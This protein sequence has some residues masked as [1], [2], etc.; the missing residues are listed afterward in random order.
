MPDPKYLTAPTKTDQMPKGIPYIIA[1]EAA[2]RFSY[3]GM[4]AILAVF[5][6]QYL[7]D[8][9]GALAVMSE[10]EANQRFHD[11]AF[12]GYFLPFVG[13]F[14]ADAFLG[15]YATILL[16]SAVYCGGHLALALDD[17]RTG[18]TVGMILIAI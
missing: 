9:S 14:L 16:V 18:L 15:K 3:Y 1:T 7:R 5:M 8:S 13:A 12:L 6:T 11:F 4:S 2:E 17:T 10:N